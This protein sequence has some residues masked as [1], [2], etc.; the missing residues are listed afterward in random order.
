[1]K[2]LLI[3][4][5]GYVGAD[6]STTLLCEKHKVT[7]YDAQWFGSGHPPDNENYTLFKGDIR[8][9]D[10]LVEAL[11]GQDAVI[12]LAS[13]TNNDA[14]N[15]DPALAFEVNEE[16]F[17]KVFS[18]AHRMKVKRFI[19]ASSVAAYGN[20]SDLLTEDMPLKPTTM[21]GQG[22][23]YCEDFLRKQSWN[24]W[25]IVR[26]ASVCGYSPRMRFDLTINKMVH[27]AF[28]KTRITVNGG[29]QVRCHVSMKD[30]NR[31]Y[32]FLLK[33]PKKDVFRQA[34]NVVSENQKVIESATIVERIVPGTRI[35]ITDRTDNRSYMVSGEKAR[36][37]LGFTPTQY[38]FDAAKDIYMRFKEGYWIYD[39][40]TN[41]S[42]FNVREG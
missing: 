21:Y 35:E 34:F 27:D 28:I 42:Y 23:A 25:T 10:K 32:A 6:L 8:D 16:V 20:S 19:Y 17:P 29:Q 24:N 26:P 5:C 2:V 13:L 36:K 40:L 31:F 38:V 39:I 11:R 37:E 41:R 14:C 33:A 1:L 9:H 18:A 12:Y 7:V 3:G 4:G 22:K 30:L 15:A